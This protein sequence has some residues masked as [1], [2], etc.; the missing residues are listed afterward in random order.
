VAEQRQELE[1]AY[2]KYG[3]I[4]ARR[5]CRLLGSEEA[6][7]EAV[8]HVFLS[9]LERPAQFEGR[10]SMLT[11]LY[12]ATTHHCLNQLRNQKTRSRLLLG[13]GSAQ[14]TDGRLLPDDLSVLR[15]RLAQLPDELAQVAVYFH[16]DQMSYDEIAEVTGYCRRKVGQLLSLLREHEQEDRNES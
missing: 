13:R 4:V 10:S 8:H 6:A 3:A 15:Q 16:L 11:F 7:W 5:A 12:E 2:K 1:W 9:L 14:L